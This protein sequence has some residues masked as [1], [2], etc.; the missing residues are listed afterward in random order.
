MTKADIQP[1]VFLFGKLV[2]GYEATGNDHEYLVDF[3]DGSSK[4]VRVYR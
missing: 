2:T 4:L 1:G 3:K